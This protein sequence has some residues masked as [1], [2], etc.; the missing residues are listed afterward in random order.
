MEYCAVK[1][2]FERPSYDYYK[3]LGKVRAGNYDQRKDKK[4]FF[5]MSRTFNSIQLHEFYIAN[6]L[7]DNTWVGAMTKEA[8]HDWKRKIVRLPEVYEDDL[9]A[10]KQ[11]MQERDLSLKKVVQ[12]E[13]GQH[14]HILRLFLGGHLQIETFTIIGEL[15]GMI[16]KYDM[17]LDYDPIWE[18]TSKKVK[19]YLSVLKN[20]YARDI[21]HYRSITK[22]ILLNSP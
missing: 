21:E 7:V 10:I 4:W 3:Y 8:W 19:K 17:L 1:A 12:V 22:R 14:P 11:F 2:H 9:N 5:R 6:F 13:S 15:T 16:D 20:E 18:P